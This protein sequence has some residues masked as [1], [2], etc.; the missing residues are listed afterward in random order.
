[1]GERSNRKVLHDK[2]EERLGDPNLDADEYNKTM[3]EFEANEE[4]IAELDER[5]AII[6]R[7]IE[8]KN[9]MLSGSGI[10][11]RGDPSNELFG[12]LTRLSTEEC[13]ALVHYLQQ[14]A[15]RYRGALLCL[16][17]KNRCLEEDRLNR[18]RD[19]KKRNEKYVK[20]KGEYKLRLENQAQEHKKKIDLLHKRVASL[21]KERDKHREE[22]SYLLKFYRD[23]EKCASNGH[24]QG[25]SDQGRSRRHPKDES[26]GHRRHHGGERRNRAE[27]VDAI[28]V[29]GSASS[30]QQNSR[31]NKVTFKDNKLNIDCSKRERV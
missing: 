8:V 7:A 30:S 9:E 27:D 1:M 4:K 29:V 17:F 19:V 2:L 10:D 31:S 25:A 5:A 21:E 16:D 24:P 14:K 3:E 22:R 12:V 20:L 26:S 28:K 13:R 15:E 18:E 6:D 11:Y 23:H